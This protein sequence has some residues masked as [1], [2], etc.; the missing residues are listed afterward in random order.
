MEPIGE[1]L[2]LLKRQAAIQHSPASRQL[3]PRHRRAR[4]LPDPAAPHPL[5][6]GAASDRLRRRRTPPTRGHTQHPRRRKALL[7][8]T[9]RG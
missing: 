9:P 6:G 1:A 5:P 2:Q 3:H 8:E 4:A 7:I